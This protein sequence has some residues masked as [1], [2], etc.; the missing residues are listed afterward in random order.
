MTKKL[1]VL[2]VDVPEPSYPK[3]Y[4]LEYSDGIYYVF[5]TNEKEMVESDAYKCTQEEAQ[6]YP[7]LKWVALEDL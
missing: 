6:K 2:L 7:Q 4:Y 5:D 3:Y 1:G